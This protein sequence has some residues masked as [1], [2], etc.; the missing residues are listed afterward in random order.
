MDLRLQMVTDMKAVLVPMYNRFLDRYQG[1]N[2]IFSIER[3]E[4]KM[5]MLQCEKDTEFTKHPEK[6]IKYK[7][8]DVVALLGRLFEDSSS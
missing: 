6:Y 3:G 5:N 4:V 2:L 7:R 8:E 1:N